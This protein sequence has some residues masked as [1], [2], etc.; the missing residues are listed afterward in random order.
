MFSLEKNKLLLE[1]EEEEL[2]YSKKHNNN[3]LDSK[4]RSRQIEELCKLNNYNSIAISPENTANKLYNT[5]YKSHNPSTKNVGEDSCKISNDNMLE[6]N[7]FTTNNNFNNFNNNNDSKNKDKDKDNKNNSIKVNKNYL[8]LKSFNLS[9]N[10]CKS[11]YTTSNNSNIKLYQVNS[12]G[13]FSFE[14]DYIYKNINKINNTKEMNAIIFH[15]IKKKVSSRFTAS[16][17]KFVYKQKE[18]MKISNK[19]IASF[20]YCIFDFFSNED[21]NMD[22]LCDL[23]F[24]D[25]SKPN[26]SELIEKLKFLKDEEKKNYSNYILTLREKH[27]QLIGDKLTDL[28]KNGITK[29]AIK[30]GSEAKGINC[31]NNYGEFT[32]S[33]NQID[34]AN[35][36]ILK[37][38]KFPPLS[39]YESLIDLSDI[40]KKAKVKINKR[41]NSVLGKNNN[42]DAPDILPV[43]LNNLNINDIDKFEHT[44]NSNKNVL[45]KENHNTNNNIVRLID[46]N[47]VQNNLFDLIKSEINKYNEINND[48]Y[49]T[50]NINNNN[51]NNNN[52]IYPQQHVK[53]INANNS[54][55]SPNNKKLNK[56]KSVLNKKNFLS[57]AFSTYKY[58]FKNKQQ[59]DKI[60][61]YYIDQSKKTIK[62]NYLKLIKLLN[63]NDN[64]ISFNNYNNNNNCNNQDTLNSNN[65]EQI[66]NL[67]KN[68]ETNFYDSDK[69]DINNHLY[70]EYGEWIYKNKFFLLF[71]K[72][73]I[74]NNISMFKYKFFLDE[75]LY[76]KSNINNH[77]KALNHN[78]SNNYNNNN[79][80]NFNIDK[81]KSNI[82]IENTCNYSPDFYILNTNNSV[83]YLSP[84][85]DLLD[86]IT[87]KE[88]NKNCNNNINNNDITYYS[89][90]IIFECSDVYD[91]N[92][93]SPLLDISL[94]SKNNKNFHKQHTLKGYFDVFLYSYLDPDEE[95]FI[96]L[97]SCIA[98]SGFYLSVYSDLKIKSLS[99]TEYLKRFK[100]FTSYST[101]VNL[102]KTIPSNTYYVLNK[103]DIILNSNTKYTNNINNKKELV[104]QSKNKSKRNSINISKKNLKCMNSIRNL[105]KNYFNLYSSLKQKKSFK[106]KNINI[107]STDSLTNV[108]NNNNLDNSKNKNILDNNKKNNLI[109]EN[110]TNYNKL[111]LV[112]SNDNA[113]VVTTS[114]IIPF[115][116]HEINNNKTIENNNE[117][118]Q[119]IFISVKFLNMEHS[120]NEFID[121]YVSNIKNNDY[122]NNILNCI[123]S[124]NNDVT[125]NQHNNYKE[126]MTTEENCLIRILNNELFDISDSCNICISIKAPININPQD[127]SIDVLG[128]INFSVNFYNIKDQFNI[129]DKAYLLKDNVVFKEQLEVHA[130]TSITMKL[131]IYNDLN[132]D[133]ELNKSN[134]YIN[135]DKESLFS[136][137]KLLDDNQILFKLEIFDEA[138]VNKIKHIWKF[139]NSL[140]IDDFNVNFNNNNNNELSLSKSNN[141]PQQKNSFLKSIKEIDSIKKSK[142]SNILDYSINENKSLFMSL[143]ENKNNINDSCLNKYAIVCYVYCLDDYMHDNLKNIL[144]S[145]FWTLSIFSTEE[146]MI[147]KDIKKF[148]LQKEIIESWTAEDKERITKGHK[149]RVKFLNTLGLF[150][151]ENYDT[152]NNLSIAVKHNDNFKGVVSDF[153]LT[154][155]ASIDNNNNNNNK[156]E[157]YAL[158]TKSS[159]SKYCNNFNKK[160]DI[161]NSSEADNKHNNVLGMYNNNIRNLKKGN[162]DIPKSTQYK[163]QTIMKFI[164]LTKSSCDQ[165]ELKSFIEDKN[166]Y[167][168]TIKDF[169]NNM[170]NIKYKIFDNNSKIANDNCLTNTTNNDINITYNKL[171]SRLKTGSNIKLKEIHLPT[172]Y[173]PVYISTVG[174]SGLNKLN[175]NNNIHKLSID[176]FYNKYINNYQSNVNLKNNKIIELDCISPINKTNNNYY[177]YNSINFLSKKKSTKKTQY[178]ILNTNINNINSSIE[179]PFINK[180]NALTK[181]NN[182]FNIITQLTQ[183]MI[184]KKKDK[185]SIN[186]NN[187]YKLKEF[188]NNN[189][190]CKIAKT[191]TNINSFY[192]KFFNKRKN[193]NDNFNDKMINNREDLNNNLSDCNINFNELNKSLLSLLNLLKSII[194]NSITSTTNNNNNNN[195][196]FFIDNNCNLNLNN[197]LVY[198][199]F[200]NE[201]E[202]NLDKNNRNNNYFRSFKVRKSSFNNKSSFSFLDTFKDFICFDIYSKDILHII[203]TYDKCNFLVK[204]NLY[205][206]ENF[207]YNKLLKNTFYLIEK[208]CFSIAIKNFCIVSDLVNNVSDSNINKPLNVLMSSSNNINKNSSSSSSSNKKIINSVNEIKTCIEIKYKYD[209]TIEDEIFKTIEEYLTANNII[210]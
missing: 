122:I 19:V 56:T 183:T 57:K 52:L 199:L 173:K 134:D 40:K 131:D 104:I 159:N 29:Y 49:V 130:N 46:S 186:I 25:I 11:N 143:N 74:I 206:K 123:E 99:Y 12:K 189:F 71:D 89:V 172:I 210:V 108:N 33:D 157:R 50:D 185:I 193:T 127:I 192:K 30:I 132:G 142:K 153:N 34:I 112:S 87:E 58:F 61:Q 176:N 3:N 200:K 53:F 67:I 8:R 47:N 103:F 115:T 73:S 13:V 66:N 27:R 152:S 155:S 9:D 170:I 161:Y 5:S 59:E 28:T 181:S 120:I 124:N 135:K 133:I 76:S 26:Y 69:T 45:I 197:N 79:N 138:C 80:N 150:S 101:I 165:E 41:I 171:S 106:I 35:T 55:K 137:F 149:S 204:N 107:M 168:K 182:N 88:L 160:I 91:S 86:N 18:V 145:V 4:R 163:S 10:L 113:S 208:I 63:V 198:I 22:R 97:E 90:L 125:N 98:S 179:T 178:N 169:N 82:S 23:E 190:D 96:V 154:T 156:D 202:D 68:L 201:L 196:N 37:K 111:T 119:G 31:I 180:H 77:S 184:N 151:D 15:N 118:D 85:L 140:I 100:D 139:K 84:S 39:Y 81:N 109:A 126:V 93:L 42:K 17:F 205:L 43:K 32:Y 114:D 191:T 62:D 167:N 38:Y 7:N 141:N 70:F 194:K 209:F 78:D 72:L 95:Y 48:N 75:L 105:N 24:K 60:I 187:Y 44:K 2:I 64:L 65:K 188:D 174:E 14:P 51:N 136:N 117:S 102:N 162:I 128:N 94:L 6:S 144:K 129:C 175:E 110:I 1:E 21:F 116:M 166:L 148:E 203:D 195:N 83:I 16:N 121:I 207:N 92:N 164:N 20:A 158:T 147:Y 146:V 177:N 54:G 36:C